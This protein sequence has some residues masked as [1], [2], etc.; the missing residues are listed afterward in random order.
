MKIL[1]AVEMVGTVKALEKPLAR[2]TEQGHSV[3]YAAAVA[4][5][6]QLTALG[7]P[8]FTAQD[9]P[10]HV[11]EESNP[12]LVIVGAA[13]GVK[14][15]SGIEANIG[16]AAMDKGL[17]VV[18]YRDYSGLNDAVAGP[19]AGHPRSGDL[20][21]F[22]MFDEATVRTVQRRAYTCREAI[23]VGSA[24]Y[25]EGGTRDW[26][27]ARSTARE[28]LGLSDDLFL[29]TFIG[30][31]SKDRVLEALVPTMQGLKMGDW[32]S[33]MRFAPLF[34]PKDPD[35]PYAPDPN[36]KGFWL[37]RPSS[38]YDQV[39]G[40]TDWV[41]REPALR[42][43]VPDGKLRIAAADFIVMN[44]LSTDTWTATY[45]QVPF[46]TA[47]V[48]LTVAEAE[49]DGI[50]VFDLDFVRVRA[51][52]IMRTPEDLV[53]YLG[54]LPRPEAGIATRLRSEESQFTPRKAAEGIFLNLVRVAKE[55]TVV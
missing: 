22:F 55:A 16:C 40:S 12:D 48:P 8:C 24:A 33:K 2:L 18:C 30:G 53:A 35:A 29:I 34:H 14:T 26:Q 38:A 3:R 28:A 19:L 47:A 31:G 51:T 42:N 32:D 4:A 45:A 50:D 44:P 6:K 1:F 52:D 49:K 36:R 54:L 23:A 5:E 43:A 7:L 13:A 46:V 17:P 11:I 9:G 10:V 20:L 41:I 21:H 39:L 15:P 25:D 27:A 37:P